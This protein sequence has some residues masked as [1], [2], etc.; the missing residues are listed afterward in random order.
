MIEHGLETLITKIEAREYLHLIKV[1]PAQS[2]VNFLRDIIKGT[3]TTIP[4]NNLAML[5]RPKIAPTKKE[6]K[7][8]MLTGLG[9][10]CTT[11]N[12]FLCA[13]LHQLGFKV[14]LLSASIMKP[15]SHIVLMVNIANL[16]YWVDLGNGFPYLEPL[17]LINKAEASHPFLKWR[18]IKQNDEWHVQHC[19]SHDPTWRT[20]QI[21]LPIPRN[22][23]FF[24][25]M[26]KDH[27]SIPDYGPF[28]TGIRI[29][30]W[31]DNG[32]VLM[33]DQFAW[34]IPGK[35]EHVNF[36]QA[37]NWIIKH[38]DESADLLTR[39]LS[40]SWDILELKK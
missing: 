35:K 26:R 8:D 33:R 14:N 37:T 6:I 5:T 23:S 21:F 29:N 34:S 36:E 28:L 12:P 40:E 38:F 1:K 4:F 19:L 18:L 16:D 30:R 7:K 32:G 3:L 22:Y 27:Y 20:N 10:L 25:Q 11:I 24:S 31:H 13:L 39:L 9:G 17:P 2:S 15:D